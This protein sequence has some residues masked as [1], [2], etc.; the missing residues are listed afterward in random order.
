MRDIGDYESVVYDG[1]NDF[2]V[3]QASYRKH[4]VLESLKKVR[5]DS[6]IVEVGCGLESM[7]QY[8]DDFRKFI[9]V[10]P[11]EKFY[12]LAL[13]QK[14]D[15]DDIVVIHDFFENTISQMPEKV[16]CIICSSL[17]HEVED[18]YGFLMHLKK[19]ADADTMVHINVPNAKSMHRLL[20]MCSGLIDDTHDMSVNNRMLQQHTVFDLRMLRELLEKTGEVEILEQGSYFVKPFTHAQMKK[21]MEEGIVDRKI[22]DGF[23]RIAEYMPEL[24]SEIFIDFKWKS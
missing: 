13:E 6:I 17:L 3:Y 10:E 11:A 16:D 23:Y 15:R 1:D 9:C 14:K 19:A 21:C 18:P 22:L 5:K 2:E 8:Y 7:F 24:G 20:A 4:R 12:R